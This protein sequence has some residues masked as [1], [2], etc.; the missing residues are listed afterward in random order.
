MKTT[1][2]TLTEV[3]KFHAHQ[4]RKVVL[5]YCLMGFRNSFGLTE[6][7]S[8]K[9]FKWASYCWDNHLPRAYQPFL[10]G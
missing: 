10:I 7:H 2:Q 5:A 8:F 1:A 3:R 9:G 6:T 4:G